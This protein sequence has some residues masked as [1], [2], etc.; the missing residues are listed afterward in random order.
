[1]CICLTL[2]F[3]TDA[4]RPWPNPPR[5]PSLRGIRPPANPS[6]AIIMRLFPFALP[7]GDE[8]RWGLLP[9]MAPRADQE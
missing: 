5:D 9:F 6:M 4:G 1:M 3:S 7:W 8:V 2:A